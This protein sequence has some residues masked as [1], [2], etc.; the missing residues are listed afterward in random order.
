MLNPFRLSSPLPLIVT[1]LMV[2]KA[3]VEPATSEPALIVVAPVYVLTPE[4]VI[5]P[6]P[7]S[8]TPSDPE[9]AGENDIAEGS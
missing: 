7:T 5:A 3:L 6:G 2:P 4:S 8:V 1:A 9:I